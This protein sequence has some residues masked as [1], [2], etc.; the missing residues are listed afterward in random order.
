M[1][2]QK[3]KRNKKYV[4]RGVGS[5]VLSFSKKEQE[6]LKQFFSECSLTVE[7]KLHRG[8]MTIDDACV[9]RDYINLT[10]L[11]AL[12]GHYI[13][14]EAFERDNRA[15]WNECRVAFHV[16]YQ[17]IIFKKTAT[18]SAKEIQAIR[19]GMEIADSLFQIEFESEPAWVV[20]NLLYMKK[21][22][23][24]PKPIVELNTTNLEKQINHLLFTSKASP[25][26]GYNHSLLKLY[27]QRIKNETR[28]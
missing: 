24:A 21:L 6:D 11:L 14:K 8:L 18:C 23:E 26:A 13:D 17:R 16:F 12:T 15:T 19:T 25:I 27:K 1:R 3:P 10:T 28:S 22:T 4:P 7:T 9:L 20:S 5:Y 2:K